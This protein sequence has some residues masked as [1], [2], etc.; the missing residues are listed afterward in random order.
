MLGEAELIRLDWCDEAQEDLLLIAMNGIIPATLDACI[1][2]W[3]A[4]KA[5]TEPK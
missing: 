3:G 2:L 1:Q 4:M 5:T